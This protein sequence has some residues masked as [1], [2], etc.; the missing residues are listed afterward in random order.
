MLRT[1]DPSN[2]TPHDNADVAP[3]Q[4]AEPRALTIDPSLRAGDKLAEARAQRGLTLEQV[5]DRL[6]IRRD[7]LE[8]LEAMNAKLLPGKAYTLA[9]LKSYA[10]E[11]G[12]DPLQI[13]EQYQS[14]CALS[15]EDVLPQVRSPRSRPRAE[16]PWMFVIALGLVAGAFVAWQALRPPVQVAAP[17]TETPGPAPA[18]TPPSLT[19]A[20]A[21]YVPRRY[22][23]RALAEARLEVR[24]ADGT[25]QLYRVMHAGEV[26]R[27]DP[28][29]G[30]TLHTADGGAFEVFV[31]GQSAGLLGDEGKPVI[32]RRLDSIEPPAIG[33]QAALPAA[34]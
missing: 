5:S 32:G 24:G 25:T 26:Y 21:D 13:V 28:S 12:L 3:T 30:W 2:S 17:A 1:N 20:G 7:F 11:V 19:E 4:K 16:R 29:P 31:D 9:Y 15:R 6:R 33:E 23:V 34:R 8:A 10:K 27:P 14:E 18:A 22:E